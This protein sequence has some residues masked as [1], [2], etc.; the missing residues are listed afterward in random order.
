MSFVPSGTI[1]FDPL[2]AVEILIC[3]IYR[4]EFQY[5]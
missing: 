4:T 3:S 2:I 1:L 5:H